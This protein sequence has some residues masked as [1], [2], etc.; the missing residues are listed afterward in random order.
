MVDSADSSLIESTLNGDQWAFAEL[1]RRYQGAV[2]GTV[3][4]ALGNSSED[5]DAVQEIF[6]RAFTALH[7][8]D[9]KYPFGP[10]ILRI[11]T[12]Y[13]IDQL[14]RR[15]GRKTQLWS[16]LNEYDQQRLLRDLSQ[17]GDVGSSGMEWME[18]YAKVAQAL[19]DGLNPKY[20]V[21]FV[22]RELEERTYEEIAEALGTSE[23]AARVR[24]SR[25]R[26]ELQKK[27]RAYLSGLQRK[28]R[29]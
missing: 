6:L 29:K 16:E 7:K 28:E 12:N 26:S 1:V 8:F 22:L 11:A 13:C 3:H 20:R 10:W 21:A 24:V 27:F 14:R 4:R 19:L 17:D 23:V 15:K 2:R 25:A 9:L 5:E 18:G